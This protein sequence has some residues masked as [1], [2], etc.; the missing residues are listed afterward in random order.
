VV[1]LGKSELRRAS[2]MRTEGIPG[3]DGSNG[4]DRG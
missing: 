4:D 2:K 1:A 3:C